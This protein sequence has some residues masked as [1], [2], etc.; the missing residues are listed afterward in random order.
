MEK[1]YT[2]T[3]LFYTQWS[4]LSVRQRIKVHELN[5]MRQDL[6]LDQ[7]GTYIILIMRELRKR[8]LLVD[9]LNE[10]QVVDIFN[11]LTFLNEPWLFFA[12]PPA[13]LKLRGYAAPDPKMGN[14]S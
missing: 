2:V 9:R 10:A 4:E 7:H 13:R 11:S 8:P 14:L 6:P 5:Q 3:D 1:Q 12:A